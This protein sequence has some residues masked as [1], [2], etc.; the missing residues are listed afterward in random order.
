MERTYEDVR[1]MVRKIYRDF[2]DNHAR[3][4][5]EKYR[6]LGSGGGD[7]MCNMIKRASKEVEMEIKSRLASATQGEG[8]NLVEV[9][10]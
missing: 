2:P 3:R 10:A 8:P 4:E 1:D 7:V 6:I 5:A 9:P